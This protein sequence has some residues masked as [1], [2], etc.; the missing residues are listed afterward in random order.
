MSDTK[1]ERKLGLL[2]ATAINMTDMVGIGPFI[3]LPMVIG[4]M[5]GP[6]F[7]YAWLAGGV[8]S[9]ID[10]MVWSEL[11]AAF[12]MAGGSYNFLKVTYGENKWGKLMS[13]L[14]V[15]QTM[16]QAPLVIASAAIGF[17]AYLSYLVP[18]T[19]LEAKMISG[20]VVVSIVALLYRKIEA[21]GKISV[22]LWA[23]VLLTLGWI[24]GGGITHGNFLE[25][26]RHINEGITLNCG[27]AAVIG[28]SCVKSVYSYLGYYNVCH[29]GG[30][31]VNPSKNIPRSMFLSIAGIAVLYLCMN[32]SVVSV[33]P[34]QQ[35]K[36][37]P[38]VISLFMQQ[39]AGP[40]AAK[41]VTALILLVAFASVFSATLGYS[42]IPYA[43]A[44]D[45]A[46][47][48]IFARLHPTGKFPYV[49]LLF[50]GAIAFI[51]SLLF[52]L[53]E[54]ISAI[55]AMRILV[56]FIAQAVGLL[57]LRRGRT[58]VDFPYKM[59]FFPLPVF[60][61]IILWGC[62]LVATGLNLFMGALVA[63]SSGLVVYLIKARLRREWPF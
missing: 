14:F 60:L 15:W 37:C 45:G 33:I 42:R 28:Y 20:G 11:G 1:Y 5:N 43:A 46:F 23:A 48:K 38:F 18:L 58:K 21:I 55:L 36:E 59:P 40:V 25:P 44:A 16:I 30:D 53:S 41:V 56:Q 9:A 29:L 51:F 39:L 62:I 63:I 27:F 61:A 10:A 24:I 49:S 31:I 17:S 4:I 19:G 32:I 8:L 2:Q 3:T 47:F 54:V 26:I 6:Y 7:L 57:I 22:V 12:P 35:A 50:L 34:W 52:K 13:F